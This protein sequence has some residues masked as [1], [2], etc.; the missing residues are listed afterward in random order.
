[1]VSKHKNTNKTGA[2]KPSAT[3]PVKEVDVGDWLASGRNAASLGGQ[4][5]LWK[6][7]YFKQGRPQSESLEEEHSRK[8]D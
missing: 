1:M 8:M 6:G 7:G 4:R 3:N 5:K 2:V